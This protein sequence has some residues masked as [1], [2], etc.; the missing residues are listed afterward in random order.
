MEVF[1]DLNLVSLSV[2]AYEIWADFFAAQHGMQT[3]SS[4]QN[5]FCPSSGF[6][7]SLRR[8]DL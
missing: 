7:T 5:S 8:N 6:R 1:G 2:F 3:R 4:D